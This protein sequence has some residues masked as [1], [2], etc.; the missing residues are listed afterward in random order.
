MR[1]LVG[2]DAG[3]KSAAVRE[4]DDVFSGSD[5][6]TF[7][8]QARSLVHISAQ[9]ESLAEIDQGRGTKARLA[10]LFMVTDRLAVLADRL[11]EQA[12]VAHDLGA[13]L[14]GDRNADPEPE[15][16]LDRRSLLEE[17]QRLVEA[18]VAT[19]ELAFD[20]ENCHVR[21]RRVALA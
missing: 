17:T 15:R 5:L 12:L 19:G 4:V 7:D 6:L 1:P 18:L 10:E 21:E 14:H 8:C 9:V 16:V 13:P 20:E 3:A 2:G 11:V